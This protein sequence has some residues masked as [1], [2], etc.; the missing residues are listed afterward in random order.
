MATV[1]KY[2]VLWV[3]DDENIV[4]STKLVA[5]NY[6][7]ELDHFSNWEEAEISLRKHFDEYS[8]IIL[9]AHCKINKDSLE[10]EEFITAVLPSLSVLF[11]EKRRSIP[12]FLLSAGTMSTFNSIVTGAKYQ[13]SKHE[14]EW[15]NM[16]YLKDVPDEDEHNS[17]FLFQ[18]I[19][20][21]AKN[22]SF[23]VVLFRHREVFSYM[24]KDKL[25]DS[26]ARK[27]VL[28]MLSALYYPEENIKYEFEGNPLRK[29][30]EYVFRASRKKGLLTPRVFDKQDHIILLDASRYLAGLNVNIYDG[31]TTKGQARWG[32]PGKEKDGANGD[33]V[34]PSDIAMIV[35]NI[36]NYSSSDSHTEEDEPFFIDESNKE[37]FFSYVLQLCH[38][39]KWFG[40]YVEINSDVTKNKSMQKETFSTPTPTKE[41]DVAP[42]N[43][44]FPRVNVERKTPPKEEIIGKMFLIST[45]NG[46]SVCGK[47]KLSD[48]LKH[49]EGTVTILNLIDNQESD[50]DKYPYIITEIKKAP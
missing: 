33:S 18:N 32:C 28:R 3:D 43:T 12:W 14:E 37:V 10:Q 40:K 46:I 16:L 7:L 25:I 35:K 44:N 45:D 41:K 8:A 17:S 24:G 20:R 23:N 2:K 48:E 49:Y 39:I 42:S 36:I 38:F 30:V 21:I 13:H 47:Y 15:G 4:V 11:G 29:V 1:D 26:R 19:Q 50:K 9:D 31:K 22:Q 27:L 6:N 34:F 5:G